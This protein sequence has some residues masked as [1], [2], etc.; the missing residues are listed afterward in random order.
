[1]TDTWPSTRRPQGSQRG[2]PNVVPGPCVFGELDTPACAR[3]QALA[4]V[5]S[6]IT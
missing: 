5:V 6:H 2:D 1:M 4:A 3:A